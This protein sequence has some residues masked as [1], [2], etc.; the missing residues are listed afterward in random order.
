MWEAARTWTSVQQ[1][2]AGLGEFVRRE[3]LAFP[4]GA[5]SR[6]SNSAYHVLGEIVARVSGQEYQDYVREHIFRPTGM[7]SA[8]FYTTPQVRENR[9]IAHGYYRPPGSADRVDNLG[10]QT[11]SYG[12]FATCAQLERF[13][14][15]LWEERLLNPAYTRLTLSGKVPL[16]PARDPAAVDPAARGPPPRDPPTRDPPA[17]HRPRSLATARS[18]SSPATGGRTNTPAAPPTAPRPCWSS[19]RTAGTWS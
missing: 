9:G 19:T 2:R 17:H 3:R 15:A 1:L 14:H 16:P 4:P 18:P 8:D 12:E 6:Y 11:F 5:G 13:A 7:G 10:E